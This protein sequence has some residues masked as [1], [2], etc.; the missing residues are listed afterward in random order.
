MNNVDLDVTMGD[1]LN[2]RSSFLKEQRAFLYNK[3]LYDPENENDGERGESPNWIIKDK[4]DVLK[5]YKE[6]S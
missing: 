5:N 4:S 2:I 6:K 1:D 3:R